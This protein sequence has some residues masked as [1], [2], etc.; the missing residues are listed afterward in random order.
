MSEETNAAPQEGELTESEQRVAE[1]EEYRRDISAD[2]R[3]KLAQEGK[4]LSDGSYPIANAE[5]LKNAATLAA[6]GH[7]NVSA[8]KALIRK[9]AKELGV[10]LSSLPGFGEKKTDETELEER[11]VT[12]EVEIVDD[13]GDEDGQEDDVA[14]S[15]DCASCVGEGTVNGETCSACDGSG[16]NPTNDEGIVER[17][18]NEE[19]EWRKKKAEQLSGRTLER[20]FFD[21]EKLEIREE[22]DG[23]WI[24]SGYASVTESPYEVGPY[25]ERI[26]RGAFKR[27]LKNE[28][29]VSLLLNHGEGGSGLPL[30]RTKGGTLTIEEDRSGLYV[31]ANLDPLD[32][33]A[34][35]LRRK[36][37]RG[38]LDGQMSFA[39]QAIDQDWND[40][41]SE[42]T[43]RAVEIN[44][45]DV[46]I[47]TQGANPATTSMIRS[48]QGA[49]DGAVEMEKR[50][51]RVLSSANVEELRDILSLSANADENLDQI[52]EKL[53]RLLGVANP[54][55]DKKAVQGPNVEPDGEKPT[56]IS[57]VASD[58]RSALDTDF[59]RR[60]RQRLEVIRMREGRERR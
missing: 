27:T 41:F 49:L 12:V 18:A 29:D 56:P 42:R 24:L 25:V 59:V 35:L 6:S 34:Q 13:D 58:G 14:P 23:G 22:K 37:L 57:S 7:G 48:L 47:V 16:T 1:I 2:E 39:F 11:D 31:E 55:E 52:Q 30:A 32:P 51:G 60:A 33:D 28:P 36:M 26:A 45:G 44:R 5:D 4:A 54:D 3:K 8:A 50:A 17:E 38:D 21:A 53:A 15:D 43:L 9:R 10:E 19:L 46:S 40:D 20:R